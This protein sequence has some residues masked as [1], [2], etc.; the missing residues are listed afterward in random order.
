MI[1]HVCC[2]LSSVAVA[3]QWVL[4]MP[5]CGNNVRNSVLVDII[6]VCDVVGVTQ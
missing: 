1:G 4:W 2:R 5:V 6:M 3:Y